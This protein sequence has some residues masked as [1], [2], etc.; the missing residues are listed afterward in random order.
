MSGYG[1][2]GFG[3]IANVSL[4]LEKGKE[5]MDRMDIVSIV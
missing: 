5:W 1:N 3:G 2:V 4:R